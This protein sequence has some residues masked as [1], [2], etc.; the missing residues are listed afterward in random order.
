MR[1]ALFIGIAL[2]GALPAAPSFV[3][4]CALLTPADIQ[5]IAGSMKVSAGVATTLPAGMGTACRYTWGTGTSAATGFWSLDINIGDAA[6]LYP[7]MGLETLK[8]GFVMQT[9]PDPANAALVSGAGEAAVYTSATPRQVN[10]TAY[11]KRQILQIGLEGAT[12][13]SKRDQAIALLKVAAG[14]LQAAP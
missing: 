4:P 1:T 6:K 13:R 10:M 7:G 5:S 2:S 9:K 14:R 8:E 11:V 3:D 12:A